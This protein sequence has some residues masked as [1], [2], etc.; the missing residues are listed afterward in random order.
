MPVS[1]SP[2]PSHVDFEQ[3][4]KRLAGVVLLRTIIVVGDDSAD[5]LTGSRAVCILDRRRVRIAPDVGEVRKSSGDRGRIDINI[6][7]RSRVA[8]DIGGDCR[9]VNR[10]YHTVDALVGNLIRLLA[11]AGP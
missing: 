6:L 9:A 11:V 3:V 1:K 4:V 2:L 10:G 5:I 8:V 7:R